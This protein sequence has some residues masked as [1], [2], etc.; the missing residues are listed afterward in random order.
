[1][2]KS[3]TLQCWLQQLSSHWL[4]GYLGIFADLLEGIFF[5]LLANF[6]F[7][8]LKRVS[9]WAKWKRFLGNIND[10]QSSNYSQEIPII[11][12]LLLMIAFWSGFAISTPSMIKITTFLLFWNQRCHNISSYIHLHWTGS[13]SVLHRKAQRWV[14]MYNTM[15]RAE[16]IIVIF[17]IMKRPKCLSRSYYLSFCPIPPSVRICL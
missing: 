11:W 16:L 7:R 5:N 17:N 10:K 2:D 4:W 13:Y 12:L 6:S 1:M 15:Y 14:T 3:I 9:L 8:R